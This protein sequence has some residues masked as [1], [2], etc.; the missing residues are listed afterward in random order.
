MRR[1]HAYPIYKM[2]YKKH[3]NI[4][5][6]YLRQFS[7]LQTMGRQ[8]LFRYDNSDRALLTG[9]CAGRYFLGEQASNEQMLELVE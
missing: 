3:V 1:A 6:N 2:D 4:V 7:N 8:G 9:I 5:Q